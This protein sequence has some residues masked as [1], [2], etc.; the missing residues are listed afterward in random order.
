[1]ASDVKSGMRGLGL[2]L[3]ALILVVSGRVADAQGPPRLVLFF[4]DDMHMDFRDTPR[5]RTLVARLGRELAREGDAWGMAT[6]GHSSVSVAPTTDWN[7]VA[8]EV[9]RLTAG[10]LRPAQRHPEEAPHRARVAASTAAAAI[11]QGAVG[12]R[13]VVVLYVSSGYVRDV[14]PEFTAVVEAASQAKAP[15]FAV[16][17]RRPANG[18]TSGATPAE[19]A[20]YLAETQDSLRGLA[21]ASEGMTVFTDADVELVLTRIRGAG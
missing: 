10:G 3:V 17:P 11:R 4:V 8:A 18:Q 16:D 7:G 13:P 1:M 6:T 20:A 21:T 2:G 12:G 19:A 14:A 15:I 9:S 5:L